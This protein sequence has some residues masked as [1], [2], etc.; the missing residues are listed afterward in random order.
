MIR[1]KKFWFG[2]IISVVVIAVLLYTIDFQDAYQAFKNTNY[3]YIVPAM[4][5]LLLS[6]FFRAVRWRY[7]LN[8]IKK[9][10]IYNLFKVT[11]IGFMTN[12]VLPARVG[13]IIR[14]YLI[15]K[16]QKISKSSGFASVIVSRLLDGL[17][18]LFFI[19]GFIIAIGVKNAESIWTVGIVSIGAYIAL[20]ILLVI[21]YRKNEYFARNI[22]GFVARFS[23]RSAVQVRS[24]IRSFKEGML[25]FKKPQEFIISM[26][27]SL[28]I[29]GFSALSI[30]CVIEG[31]GFQEQLPAYTPFLV[32]SLISLGIAIP[33]SPG[34]WGTFEMSGVFAI[35]LCN[36]EIPNGEALSF[37]FLLHI[38]QLIPIVSVG[39]L[40]LWLGNLRLDKLSKKEKELSPEI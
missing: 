2:V 33:S 39:F 3:L 8:P 25:L 22:A 6:F 21:F 14:G 20:A 34:F 27:L 30:W 24:G 17:T 26:L 38:T 1:E 16:D 5:V 32:L 11:M 36:S 13:E 40:F 10:P 15:A 35:R 29:W 9:I 12:F 4:F 31:F 7:V 18:I 23:K 28:L 37:T 19:V